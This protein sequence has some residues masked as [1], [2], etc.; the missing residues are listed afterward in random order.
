VDR[1]TRPA[2]QLLAEDLEERVLD[3]DRSAAEAAALRSLVN[4]GFGVTH[5]NAWIRDARDFVQVDTHQL[6]G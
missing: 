3:F 2:E 4:V 1:S 6:P 5:S